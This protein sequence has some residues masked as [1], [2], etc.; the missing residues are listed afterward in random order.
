[1]YSYILFS[2]CAYALKNGFSSDCGLMFITGFIHLIPS[3]IRYFFNEI[4]GFI[5]N[6]YP[7]HYSIVKPGLQNFLIHFSFLFLLIY[8]AI[9]VVLIL[10]EQR[11]KYKK[12]HFVKFYLIIS[13]MVQS[14][15][16]IRGSTAFFVY[17]LAVQIVFGLLFYFLLL[18]RFTIKSVKK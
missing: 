15:T 5:N 16:L 18:K 11:V 1:M 10:I 13:I 7:Y 6:T 9:F 12:V 2:L 3:Q 17:Y 8:P 14:V 4:Q